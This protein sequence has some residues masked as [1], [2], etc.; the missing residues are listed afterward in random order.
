MVQIPEINELLNEYIHSNEPGASLAVMKNNEIVH[1]AGYGLANVEW[2]IPN[3][4]TTVFRIASITKQFTAIAIMMLAE[5]GKLSPEDSITKFLSDYPTSGHT[6][7]IHHLLTHTSGLWDMTNDV[8]FM[9]DS[10][11]DHTPAEL[12]AT[13]SRTPFDFAP[14]EKYAYSNSGYI[15]LGMIIEKISGMSY[16][17]F[18]QTR[19]FTPLNMTQSSYLS[20]EPIILKRASGYT[21][22]QDNT[23]L[24]APYVSMTY[25]YAAGS[26]GSTGLDLLKW[27]Q[28]LNTLV[29]AETLA[30]MRSRTLLNDGTLSDYGYGWIIGEFEG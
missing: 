26:L 8:D 27:Y 9:R 11:L 17:E 14:G 13:F 16:A 10:R 2:G 4:P 29:S 22:D 28:G 21:R 25:P 20:N 23:L 15:L 7:T 19:I 5:E 24:N 1:S 6:V 12:M 18:I 30:K 3:T